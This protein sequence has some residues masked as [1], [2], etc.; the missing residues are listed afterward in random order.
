MRYA[1]II[2]FEKDYGQGK[3]ISFLHIE[4]ILSLF[5]SLFLKKITWPGEVF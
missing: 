2:I 1:G 4:T 5:V 3:I